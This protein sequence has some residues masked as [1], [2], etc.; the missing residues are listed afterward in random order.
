EINL[1]HSQ[2]SELFSA[3]SGEKQLDLPL[4]PRRPS[5]PSLAG[6]G[7]ATL[8]FDSLEGVRDPAESIR[9]RLLWES[10][11]ESLPLLIIYLIQEA[12]S[13]ERLVALVC[14]LLY[15]A[16][17]ALSFATVLLRV[18]FAVLSSITLLPCGWTL[19]LAG[20]YLQLLAECC[21]P[22]SWNV[23]QFEAHVSPKGLSH[24]EAYQR[25]GVFQYTAQWIKNR[26]KSLAAET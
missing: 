12:S 1:R 25:Y 16:P 20:P 10:V 2:F 4:S 11:V 24:S 26:A 17:A 7:R 14:G 19:P 23:T 8:S 15:A 22:G 5:P 18:P 3:P 21:P 6:L 13:I 9:R